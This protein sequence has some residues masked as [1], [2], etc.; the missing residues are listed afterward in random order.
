LNA[1]TDVDCANI[2]HADEV[3]QTGGCQATT[4]VRRISEV[5]FKNKPANDFSSNK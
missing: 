3:Q 5:A 2:Y 4:L 1:L